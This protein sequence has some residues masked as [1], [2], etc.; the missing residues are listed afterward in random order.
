M[1][2]PCEMNMDALHHGYTFM[3]MNAIWA[4]FVQR[5]L[6]AEEQFKQ[7][8]FSETALAT[9]PDTPT[10]QIRIQHCFRSLLKMMSS[11][12]HITSH[13]LPPLST[14]CH[15]QPAATPVAFIK[16]TDTKD[17][18]MDEG[19]GVQGKAEK[20]VGKVLGVLGSVTKGDVICSTFST[21]LSSLTET[22]PSTHTRPSAPLDTTP[23]IIDVVK[24]PQ[25][26]VSAA[27]A[28]FLAFLSLQ[29]RIQSPADRRAQCTQDI[30]QEG[31][32]PPT[33]SFDIHV[34]HSRHGQIGD[35]AHITTLSEACQ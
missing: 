7:L 9:T 28:R 18:L 24:T 12:C 14:N 3:N 34:G 22:A 1:V 16:T 15:V 21:E 26:I 2:D 27:V 30:L 8:C 29:M 31:S 25:G 19:K 35:A 20:T 13:A 23:G 32:S 6:K 17:N 4:D 11:M 10:S 5:I 33:K